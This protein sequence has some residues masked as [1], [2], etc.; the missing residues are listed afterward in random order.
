M[1]VKKNGHRKRQETY[2]PKQKLIKGVKPADVARLP[3]ADPKRPFRVQVDLKE[4]GHQQAEDILASPGA[5]QAKIFNRSQLIRH[6]LDHASRNAFFQ[7]EV[8]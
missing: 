3:A 6:L 5:R 1:A 2:P 8:S 7:G 4:K